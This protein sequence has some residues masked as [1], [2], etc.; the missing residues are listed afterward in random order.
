VGFLQ[1]NKFFDNDNDGYFAI[2][3]PGTSKPTTAGNW[4]SAMTKGLIVMI[5]ILLL[6]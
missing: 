6:E 2:V 3:Q 5:L 4:T 1:T